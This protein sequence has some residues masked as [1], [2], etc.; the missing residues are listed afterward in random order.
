MKHIIDIFAE[1]ARQYPDRTAVVDCDGQLTYRELD[2][3][4]N[5]LAHQLH[6]KTVLIMLPRRSNFLM[7]AFG[8]LKTGGCYIVVAAC[9]QSQRHP[10]II[11]P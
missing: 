4:S 11:H 8:T 2:E 10:P 9:L 6:A 3:R 7:A 5:M 1:T